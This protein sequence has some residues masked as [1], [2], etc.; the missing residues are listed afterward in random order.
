MPRCV[1]PPLHFGFHPGP[2]TV[3]C[4]VANIVKRREKCNH[5]VTQRIYFGNRRPQSPSKELACTNLPSISS[6]RNLRQ[7]SIIKGNPSISLVL[8]VR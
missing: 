8:F 5:D 1:L 6:C 3:V 4:R 7:H 2:S